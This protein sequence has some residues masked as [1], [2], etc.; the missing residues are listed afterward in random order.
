MEAT[1]I[2]EA[3]NKSKMQGN[4]QNTPLDELTVPSVQASVHLVHY[5][6]AG[7]NLTPSDDPTVSIQDAPDELQRRSS[8][9]SSTR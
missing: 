3:K 5:A 7:I 1:T 6:V 2:K 9:D 8:E 4:K